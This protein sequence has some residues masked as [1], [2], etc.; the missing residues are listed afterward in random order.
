MF[1]I[2]WISTPGIAATG[3]NWAKTEAGKPKARSTKAAKSRI[4]RLNLGIMYFDAYAHFARYRDS[5][6]NCANTSP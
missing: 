6:V 1:A 5:S 3:P 2:L 4:I